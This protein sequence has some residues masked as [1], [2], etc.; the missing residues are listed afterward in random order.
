ML[1]FEK[2]KIG[3]YDYIY[4]FVIIIYAGMAIPAT[5]S[6]MFYNNDL[7]AFIIPI[8]L[9]IIL[10]IKHRIIYIDSKV[11]LIYLIFTLWVILQVIKYRQIYLTYTFFLYYNLTIAILLVKIYGFKLFI[12][13]EDILVKLSLI[14]ILGWMFSIF[15]YGIILDILTTVG[16]NSEISSF[17]TVKSNILIFSLTSNEKYS[18]S[19]YAGLIRNSGFSWEPGRYA[20]MVI[21][22]I[23]IN[24]VRCNFKVFKNTNFW[25]LLIALLS[26]Q[27]TT[28][29]AFLILLLFL[30]LYNKRSNKIFASILIIPFML[31]VLTLPFMLDKITNLWY[32]EE[33]L[34]SIV[35]YTNAGVRETSY[36][37]QRFDAMYM[38]FQNLIRDPILGYGVEIKN[39]FVK[40]QSP[41]I[42]TPHGLITI[43][44]R[45]GIILGF[46]IFKMTYRTSVLISNTYKFK[47]KFFYLYLFIVMSMSYDITT[48]P[49]FL[50]IIIFEFI[51]K[52]EIKIN[53]K[54]KKN[55]DIT[56]LRNH[57]NDIGTIN[58]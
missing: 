32:N 48:V 24:F 44:S 14:A 29:F 57:L 46:L 50:A 19:M 58:Q 37:L 26:T 27:S 55:K 34:N 22:A 49:L 43:F 7:L 51:Y 45:F 23:F 6:M 53:K 54:A 33:N 56:L 30:Y 5:N 41:F 39:S 11:L 18:D 1:V 31:I 47:G 2:Y 35:D 25:I 21:L 52:P 10:V 17:A 9:T 4:L 28:G 16:F 42:N 36:S 12:L 20:I 38:Q 15:F 3:I 13:Y 8:I 40:K